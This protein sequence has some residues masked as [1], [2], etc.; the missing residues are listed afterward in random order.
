VSPSGEVVISAEDVQRLALVPGQHVRVTV[1]VTGP[2]RRRSMYGALAGRLSHVEPSD[3]GRVRREV[4][5]ELASSC[6][7]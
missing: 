2:P 5:G 1:T 6:R 7:P 4:W 3:I